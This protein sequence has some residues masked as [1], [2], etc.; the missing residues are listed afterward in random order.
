MRISDWSSDVCSS[1][2]AA[3]H[4]RHGDGGA[5][6]RHGPAAGVLRLYPALVPAR[7]AGFHR[8]AACLLADAGQSCA[9]S[10]ATMT[11]DHFPQLDT[12]RLVLRGFRRADEAAF[13]G[14]APHRSEEHTSEL[15]SL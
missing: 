15:Q 2:L 12:A 13:A 4:P 8:P 10:R 7:L 14:F 9:G 3:A 11:I 5:A 6:R 1:E